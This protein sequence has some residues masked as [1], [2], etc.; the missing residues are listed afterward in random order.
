MDAA[1]VPVPSPFDVIKGEQSLFEESGYELNDKEWIAGRLLVDQSCQRASFFRPAMK[2]IRNQ[3]FQI[4]TR[5]RREYDVVHDHLGLADVLQLA[6]Q[7][8]C[9][10]Y[11]VVTVGPDQHQVADIRM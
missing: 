6:H 7:R 2:R 1:Y 9:M 8:M 4:V 11:L 3:L 10:G 5:Q